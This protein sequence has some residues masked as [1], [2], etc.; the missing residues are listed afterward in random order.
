MMALRLLSH[1]P[2]L[3]LLN[4]HQ[5]CMYPFT[6]PRIH[7][8]ISPPKELLQNPILYNYL[9]KDFNF[10]KE[11]AI[12]ISNRFHYI[13]L[14]RPQSAVEYLKSF[15][16]SHSHIQ[17]AVK[18]CP[19]ILF[20]NTEKILGPKLRFFQELGFSGSDFNKF[21][22]RNACVLT[23][24]LDDTLKPCVETVKRI[25]GCDENNKD[26]IHVLLRCNWVVD[27]NVNARIVSNASY[28]KSCGIK[29]NQISK[30]FKRQPRLLAAPE[31]E[32]KAIVKKI[33]EMGFV[34]HSRM[35][36]YAIHTV[37]SMSSKTIEKKLDVIR[38]FGFSRDECLEM[39]RRAPTLPRTSE[40]K[41][42]CAMKFFLDTVKLKKSLIVH[43][44]MI[45]MHSVE[46]RI[47]AR[48][49]VLKTLMEKRLLNKEPAFL[50]V[51]HMTEEEFL[52]KYI[53][54]FVDN[55]E[56]LLGAYKGHLLESST[57]EGA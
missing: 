51:L 29:D 19:Q 53:S 28:L 45:L 10:P 43:A 37:G 11:K 54:K 44:P 20:S 5:R 7:T 31:S 30:L 39:F 48:Y 47:F 24:S 16:F 35:L 9:I 38:S 46:D 41:L 52:E 17:S 13:T 27:K 36:V 40:V 23:R 49:R 55:A 14:E 34:M 3:N 50:Y 25:L 2:R 42:R 32:L 1:S 26:L 4:L 22:S 8:Y 56:E 15:G 57:E 12:K 6:F 21:I 18:V 33:S